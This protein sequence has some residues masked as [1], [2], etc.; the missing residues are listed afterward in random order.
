M[1]QKE[2]GKTLKIKGS[3][4]FTKLTNKTQN[5]MQIWLLK[6]MVLSSVLV[7]LGVSRPYWH[8]SSSS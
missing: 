2:E 4:C 8:D 6:S 5:Q 3:F 1:E 7:L